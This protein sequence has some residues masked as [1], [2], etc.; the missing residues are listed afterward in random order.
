MEACDAKGYLALP[1]ALAERSV[2]AE[3]KDFP[4]RDKPLVTAVM[5]GPRRVLASVDEA[6]EGLGFAAA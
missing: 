4:S 2:A 6:A 3:S 1:A 5:Q